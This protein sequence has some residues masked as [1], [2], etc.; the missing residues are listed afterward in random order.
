MG[1]V[2]FLAGGVGRGLRV[3]AG[4]VLGL[5]GAAAGGWWLLLAPA[6]LAIITA[7]PGNLCVPA[8]LYGGPLAGSRAA[9]PRHR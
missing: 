4:L 3:A 2:E 5:L 8:P 9:R 6:G 7:G 1:V